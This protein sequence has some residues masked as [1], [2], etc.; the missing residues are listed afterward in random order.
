[1]RLWLVILWLFSSMACFSS[2]AP[3]QVSS[4]TRPRLPTPTPTTTP[5]PYL[6]EEILSMG[7]ANM[8][9]VITMKYMMTN[10]AKGNG[11]GSLAD[12]KGRFQNPEQFYLQLNFA[13]D[14]VEILS[15]SPLEYYWRLPGGSTWE[16]TTAGEVNKL[17]TVSSPL[18]LLKLEG[19]ALNLQK[20]D[21]E[22]VDGVDC[23]HIRFDLDMAKYIEM[24]GYSSLGPIDLN[25]ATGI[26]Q[27][28]AGRDDMLFRQTRIEIVS[29]ESGD[30]SSIKEKWVFYN[31]NEP[32]E[33]PKP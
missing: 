17:Y 32:V 21:N 13:G 9:A 2:A 28:W 15:L 20:L 27:I 19:M 18:E 22:Q 7:T 16:P 11:F 6:A 8:K 5:F 3:T 4:P 12:G 26:V 10:S 24:I 29:T 1:M 14:A 23:Y 30:D 33:I 31:F 25:R